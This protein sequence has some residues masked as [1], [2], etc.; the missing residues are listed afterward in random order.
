MINELDEILDD[1]FLKF[2]QNHCRDCSSFDD[3]IAEISD[4]E[5]KNN[6]KTKSPKFALQSYAYV[7]LK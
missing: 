6:S 1:E 2:C 3:I 4:I 7:Y 5:I